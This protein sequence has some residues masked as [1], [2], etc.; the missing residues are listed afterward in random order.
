MQFKSLNRSDDVFNPG[1][2]DDALRRQRE[3]EEDRANIYRNSLDRL[4]KLPE[5]R[6]FLNATIEPFG[7]WRR[8]PGSEL[9][10]FEMGKR[11]TI[12]IMVERILEHGGRGARE[13]YSE[14]S[15]KFADFLQQHNHRGKRK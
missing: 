8:Q 11:A 4:F 14:A 10:S 2:K 12:T 7:Y 3:R 5:F 6:E 13:W 15:E 9:P 1:E